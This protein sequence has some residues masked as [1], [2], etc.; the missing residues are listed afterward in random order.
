MS[1]PATELGLHHTIPFDTS[2]LNEGGAFDDLLHVFTCPVDGVYMFMTALLANLHENTA[3]EI[4]L[5]G[6][7][8]A[9]TYSAGSTGGHGHDQ[10]FNSVITKCVKGDRVWVQIHG[11]QG[12]T[13][14]GGTFNTF[15][16]Y[17][18]G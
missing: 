10:G 9:T 16:G 15:S 17:R 14:F 5:N 18:L 8:L 12:T 2:T 13:V 11:H 3:T 6:N 4:V 1:A 7:P